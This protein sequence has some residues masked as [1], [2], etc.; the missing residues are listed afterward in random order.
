[1]YSN[2][3]GNLSFGMFYD[4]QWGLYIHKNLK[5]EVQRS[6]ALGTQASWGIYYKELI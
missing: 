4:E 2:V 3:A 5:I 6:A 1:M